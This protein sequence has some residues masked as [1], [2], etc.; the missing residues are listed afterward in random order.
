MKKEKISIVLMLV[1]IGVI[2]GCIVLTE[3]IPDI[4]TEKQVVGIFNEAYGTVEG[5][6]GAIALEIGNETHVFIESRGWILFLIN[7]MDDLLHSTIEVTF[8]ENLFGD[9]KIVC[10]VSKFIHAGC[11]RYGHKYQEDFYFSSDGFRDA[12]D[13]C[14]DS[15]YSW[16]RFSCDDKL[17]V[18][19]VHSNNS[20]FYIDHNNL[21]MHS[22]SFFIDNIS[23]AE[24]IFKFSNSSNCRFE[25]IYIFY[26][27]NWKIPAITIG[28]GIRNIFYNLTLDFTG[29]RELTINELKI[30]HP[31]ISVRNLIQF[32]DELRREH[33]FAGLAIGE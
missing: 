28:S 27:V 7:N 14:R 9:K 18:E 21:S 4:W 1:T 17:I 25:H 3:V 5:V 16:I 30:L 32:A 29:N 2:A 20:T 31:E 23:S 22:I 10:I 19:G 8:S 12:L 6:P 33:K 11:D 15:N 24:T 13:F 26:N